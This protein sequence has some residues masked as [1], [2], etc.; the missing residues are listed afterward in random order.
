MKKS[1]LSML[2]LPLVVAA[3]TSEEEILSDKT[4]DQYANIPTVEATFNWGAETRMNTKWDLEE[5]DKVGLAWLGVPN[6]EKY[7]GAELTINGNAY[8]NHPLYATASQMLQPQTSIYVGKYFSYY[9]Y[10]A[11]TVNIDKIKF[12]VAEQ[13]LLDKYADSEAYAK[14]A[15]TSIWISPKWTDVTLTGDDETGYNQ[16]GVD[17]TF[18]M[19]PRQFTNKAALNFTY[20]NNQPIDVI[21]QLPIGD[22]MIDK[23]KV[24]YVKNGSETTPVNVNAFTYNPTAE[25]EFDLTEEEQNYWFGHTFKSDDLTA[26]DSKFGFV[27]NLKAGE[28]VLSAES[29]E[30]VATTNENKGK[31]YYNALPSN[32]GSLTENDKVVITIECTYGT[33]TITKPF[34]KIAKTYDYSLTEPKYLENFDGNTEKAVAMDKSFVNKLYATGNFTTDVDFSTADMNGMHVKNDDH[35]K[36]LLKFFRSYRNTESAYVLNLDADED[37]EFKLSLASI[38]MLQEINAGISDSGTK[39]IAIKACSTH[40]TPKIVINGDNNEIPD[41]NLCFA[42]STPVT[43]RGTWTWAEKDAKMRYYVNNIFN[44][45]T[46]TVTTANVETY[47]SAAFTNNSNGIINVNTVTNWKVPTTNYGTINIAEDAELRVYGTTLTNDATSLE[48]YGK[49]YNSGVLGVVAGTT[50]PAINNYGYIKN[51]LN[52]KTYVTTNQYGTGF[53]VEFNRT[54]NKIGTIE[55]TTATDNVSVSNATNTGFIKYTWD[56]AA[57]E[58]GKYVTPSVDVKYNYLIVTKDIELVD[59][60]PEIQYIEIAGDKEVVITCKKTSAFHTTRTQGS[61]TIDDR[62]G[63]ILKAGQ[64]ANI[65]EGNILWTKGAFLKGTLYL[66]GDFA[67][68]SNLTTYFGGNPATDINNII[69]YK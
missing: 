12:S 60:A 69:Q 2:A 62:I 33:V 20:K 44:E 52:A 26:T 45:G 31:F 35:L 38:Q 48:D 63:F 25:I 57:N 29:K 16:A 36:Q 9:P 40:T 34:N 19:Y 14:S 30:G 32:D 7:G 39:K 27:S 28:V 65:K 15:K 1:I 43:L 51:N 10:D 54:S 64:K 56:D 42:T 53:A 61:A 41:M 3:C 17:K 68:Y 6:D 49:I 18:N 11:E 23:V 37:G 21:E 47:P 13:P 50:S 5:G 55:L 4:N 58:D 8:Q 46:I 67:Y 66:G 22:V 59:A 24:M